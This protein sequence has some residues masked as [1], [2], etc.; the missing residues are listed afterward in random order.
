MF[1]MFF[2]SFLSDQSSWSGGLAGQTADLGE[3]RFLLADLA[4]HGVR[5]EV[6][7]VAALEAAADV[8]TLGF[9]V[10]RHRQGLD[11]PKVGGEVLVMNQ[12]DVERARVEVGSRS[13]GLVLRVD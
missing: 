8:P 13:P 6:A 3:V 12:G 9:G 2:T 7:V 1:L 5:E 10:A 4:L 11:V